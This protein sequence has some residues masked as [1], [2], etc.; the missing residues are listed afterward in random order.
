MTGCG[1][2]R[3]ASFSDAVC[4]ATSPTV[5]IQSPSSDF[6]RSMSRSSASARDGR[7]DRNG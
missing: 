7:P 1:Q 3:G 2:V 6:I 4:L 5:V